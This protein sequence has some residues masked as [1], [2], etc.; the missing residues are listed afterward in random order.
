MTELLLTA[1]VL[2]VVWGLFCLYALLFAKMH[3]FP[4]PQPT[5]T[6]DDISLTLDLPGGHSTP[7]LWLPA[8]D[9]KWTLLFL[10]GNAEDLGSVRPVIDDHHARGYSVFAVEYPGYGLSTG[11]A[12][13]AGNYAAC[14][15]ACNY[16]TTNLNISPNQIILYGRSLG[17]GPAVE[18]A[19]REPVAGM[20]LDGAFTSIF[21][22]VTRWKILPWDIFDN[23]AKAP[24]VKCPTLS[25]HGG[26]DRTVP[27]SHARKLHASLPEPKERFWVND[28]GHVNLI[29][30]TGESYW[31]ALSK[32]T[33]LIAST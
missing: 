22:V 16:L 5:Y 8:Q 33:N 26:Q 28:A 32:F 30:F 18:L 24:R 4:A 19:T 6:A 11:N 17:S 21:R 29:E 15:A 23:L 3:V 27:F 9:A 10:H 13:E 12:S 20:I 25:I 1:G 2:A 31:D 14:T 7:A